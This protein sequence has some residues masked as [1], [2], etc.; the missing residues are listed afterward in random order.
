MSGESPADKV[1]IVQA[2]LE[3]YNAQDTAAFAATYA[4]DV[5]VAEVGGEVTIRGRA[6][7]FDRYAKLFAEFPDNRAEILHRIVIGDRV[8]DHERVTRRADTIIEVLA[9]YT[10]TDGLIR[11]V[12]FIK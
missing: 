1:A 8:V 5:V 9:V 3:A 6:A 12:D 4:E 7:L 10:V 11:R 2:Q